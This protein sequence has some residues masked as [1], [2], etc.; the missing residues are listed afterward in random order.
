MKSKYVE[1]CYT[2]GDGGTPVKRFLV[3]RLLADSFYESPT[4]SLVLRNSETTETVAVFSA[5]RWVYATVVEVRSAT[6]ATGE[7]SG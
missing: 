1:V 6:A 3:K 7:T 5:E 4:G 2:D